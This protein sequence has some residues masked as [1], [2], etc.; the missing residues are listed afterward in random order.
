VPRKYLPDPGAGPG[1]VAASWAKF[2]IRKRSKYLAAPSDQATVVITSP[3]F[4]T[5]ELLGRH[6]LADERFSDMRLPDHSLGR[7][8]DPVHDD[9]G[10]FAS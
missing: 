4:Y 9:D 1:R 2:A 8:L 10:E 5:E 3:C 7:W 6:E